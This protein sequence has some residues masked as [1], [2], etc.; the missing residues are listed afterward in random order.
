MDAKEHLVLGPVISG[1][2]GGPVANVTDGNKALGIV[3]TVGVAVNGGA[4]TV[5]HAGEGGNNLEFVLSDAA[6]RGFT[7]ALRT[8]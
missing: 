2:S 7:V 3:N 8:I 5:A 6:A 1:D 4:L